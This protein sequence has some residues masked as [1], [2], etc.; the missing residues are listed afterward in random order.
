[1]EPVEENEEQKKLESKEKGLE[2]EKEGEE[3]W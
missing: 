1:M 3:T 2:E